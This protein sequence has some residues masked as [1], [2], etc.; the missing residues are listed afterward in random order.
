MTA[1]G[2]PDRPATIVI[3]YPAGD[4]IAALR[5][6]GMSVL[7]RTLRDAAR[8]G[9]TRAL[10]RAEA[11]DLPALPTLAL[12]V[13]VVGRDAAIPAG[14]AA[15]P[16]DVVGGV[17][18]HDRGSARAAMRAL[19]RSCRRPHDGVAD[20]YL[21]RYLSLALT[22]SLTHT[23]ITPNQVTI[24][25]VVVGFAACWFAGTGS[26]AAFALAGALMILQLVLDSSDGEL[27]RIRHRHSW[28]GM[29][30][31]NIG[32][33]VVDNLFIASLGLGLGGPW[34]WLGLGAAALRM[35]SA[36]M[37]YVDVAR[38]GK[39]GDIMAFHWWLD[40]DD[41][42]LE[43][44]FNPGVTPMTVVRALGRRD[45]YGLTFGVTCLAGVPQVAFG[46]GVAICLGYAALAVLHL[47]YRG[48]PPAPR[49]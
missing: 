21:I 14:A 7:E 31:D 2:A 38:R 24:A 22:R 8:A 9:A 49:P 12:A 29:T 3:D 1:A 35:L 36:G 34:A 23:P 13:D 6:G 40:A 33:D 42:T 30:L 16:G 46:L 25:N 47:R 37:I 10:V 44:R 41:D 18:V 17:R 48:L 20:R 19:L 28:F 11:G 5:I 26:R 27:A 39:P 43:E 4:K 15:L 45:L 32:D